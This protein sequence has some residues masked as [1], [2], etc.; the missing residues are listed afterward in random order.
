MYL[1]SREKRGEV[2]ELIKEQLRK[3]YIRSSKSLQTALVFFVENKNNKKRIVQNYWHL[4]EW[5]IK[6]NYLLPL[7]LNIVEKNSIK[8]VFTKLDLQ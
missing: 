2:H 8:K 4:N 3:G 6:K 5:T 1:L 7:I